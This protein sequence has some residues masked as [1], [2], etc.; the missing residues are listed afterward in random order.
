MTKDSTHLYEFGPFRLDA[1]ERQLWRDGEEIAL[2]P[3]A[4]GVLLMLIRNSGHAVS[5]EDFMREVWPDTIVEEKNLTD[6]ISI[7]RQALGDNTQ[8][9]RY[10]KT[11]PRRGY[12]FVAGVRATHAND[13]HL[14]V[15]ESVRTHVL[16]E[17]DD[18]APP[19]S[20]QP[21][22]IRALPA[23]KPASW[24]NLAILFAII[25]TVAIGLGAYFFLRKRNLPPPAAQQFKSLA[26]L[27][28]K[29]L[30]AA[31]SDDAYLG[32]GLA[33]AL[34]NRLS[35]VR[36]IAIR[37]TSAVLKYASPQ[38][39]LVSVAR[40]QQVDAVLDGSFQRAGE[41]VR[42][43][44][45][46]VRGSDGAPLW[47]GTF[48]EKFTDIFA[49]QDSISQRVAGALVPRLSS[50]ENAALTKR[51]AEN[52]EAYRLYLIGHY[53]WNKR[54]AEG[55][56]SALNYYQQAIAADPNYALAYAGLAETHVLLPN[57]TAADPAESFPKAERA[58]RR[59]LELDP[60]L[61]AAYA[62]LGAVKV[63]YQRD[64]AGAGEDY[65][66]AIELN[67][68]YATA[69]QWY[70]EWLTQTGRLEEAMAEAAAAQRLDPLSPIIT[71]E[72]G[73][74]LYFAHRPNE[75]S[76]QFRRALEL[77]PGFYRANVFL[78]RVYFDQGRYEEAI[79]ERALTFGHG[80]AA[81]ARRF[82]GKLAAAYRAGGADG[83]LR[84]TLQ[85]RNEPGIVPN[86]R[87]G[88]WAES[89]ARLGDTDCT[90]EALREAERARHPIVDTIKVDPYFDFIRADPRYTELLRRLN[91]PQ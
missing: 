11:I 49:L 78:S 68:N 66:R 86:Q 76:E 88:I 41:R 22:P 83:Y 77:Q 37:P 63:S 29:P 27:P 3:K 21:P 10:I 23:P 5:K 52:S 65:R 61:A 38:S 45:Q 18:Y 89:C 70:S 82:E 64:W 59:A 74:T 62:A 53:F 60:N 44:V 73:V 72:Y 4:F 35:N 28:L 69:R 50:Q 1:A 2:T 14:L 47:A 91:L 30:S 8:E 57:W 84:Q 31:S 33:D 43:T 34:I 7:L 87:L 90:F 36:Q 20:E 17:A 81:E 25:A 75:A 85:M 54:T 16:I 24:R 32:V 26:I 56:T 67:P 58:A 19:I 80:D 51:E 15:T 48:D 6:N 46:L 39:D 71:F 55:F 12:R 13:G 40:E 79:R 9:Q 42:V